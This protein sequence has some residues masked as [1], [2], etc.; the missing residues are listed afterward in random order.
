[1]SIGDAQ[2][3][4]SPPEV[5]PA[6]DDARAAAAYAETL[7]AAVVAMR[8]ASLAQRPDG[9][10]LVGELERIRQALQ[11]RDPR[12]IR[13]QAGMLGRLLGSDVERQAQ[14]E[15]FEQQLGVTLLRAGHQ[16][17]RLEREVARQATQPGL[18]DDAAAMLERWIA[19]AEL[20]AARPAWSGRLDHLRRLALLWRGEAA[21]EQLLQAQ[22]QE[23]LAR[24][25][26]IR[27]VL[28]PAWRQAAL[29]GQANDGAQGLMRAGEVHDGIAA[30]I[31]AM[32]AR[33]PR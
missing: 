11:A 8:A 24:Y 12:T 10:G 7:L 22:M 13:R 19:A 21:Q 28:L 16:A 33:L 9:V 27:D 30:E 23:L 4:P 17:Q 29:A 20:H 6:G 18:L 5:P 26:R 25:L 2:T 32:Q 31:A 14:A 15:M 1:M 3:W